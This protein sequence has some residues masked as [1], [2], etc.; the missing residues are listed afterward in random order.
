MD[1]NFPIKSDAFLNGEDI[2][3]S[4]FND[5][6]I[7]IEDE[8]QENFYYQV[9]TKLFPSIKIEKIFPLNGKPNII[10]NAKQTINEKNKIY[11]VDKDFDD[12]LGKIENLPNLFYLKKYSIEN[13]LIE[14]D[15]IHNFI[16]DELPKIKKP[17]II[18][19]FSLDE[20]IKESTSLFK[21]ITLTYMV[22]QKY[23]L[24]I[25]N[26]KHD[27]NLFFIFNPK[28]SKK[29]IMIHNYLDEIDEALKQKI[30]KRLSIK[31]QLRRF[32]KN[33]DGINSIPGKYLIK[34]LKSRICHL[35][36][37][38]SQQV[39]LES[40]IYRLAKNCRFDSLS[41]LKRPISDFIK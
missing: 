9:L 22:I 10:N 35:F 2:L 12:F 16:I 32:N 5:I 15:S 20:F 28:S 31:G 40:F 26:V 3:Y 34:F 38:R 13:Y 17:D 23:N 41:Y 6:N 36:S 19:K 1:K 4:Q 24:G 29:H 33:F 21:E 11:I 30:D 7:Y 8:E 25:R 18:I 37:L 14:E 39:Q 27:P